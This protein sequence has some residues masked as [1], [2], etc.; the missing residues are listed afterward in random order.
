MSGKAIAL[1]FHYTGWQMSSPPSARDQ[2]LQVELS[3]MERSLR[4]R[5]I[6][7]HIPQG[8]RYALVAT[9][10]GASGEEIV[11][12]VQTLAKVLKRGQESLELT[13]K[14]IDG[15]YSAETDGDRA[16]CQELIRGFVGKG[17]IVMVEEDIP[18]PSCHSV[19]K[20]G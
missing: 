5:G 15:S 7:S 16:E 19:P 9:I 6:P 2:E 11:R 14:R 12:G 1:H 3:K 18:I 20:G 8:S 10:H 17:A 13:L 4:E